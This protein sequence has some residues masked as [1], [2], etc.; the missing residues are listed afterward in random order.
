MCVSFSVISGGQWCSSFVYYTITRPS[1]HAAPVGSVSVFMYFANLY[2]EEKEEIMLCL[3][4]SICENGM[5][6]VHIARRRAS[7]VYDTAYLSVPRSAVRHTQVLCE[8][9]GTQRDAIFTV[10]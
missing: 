9:E 4:V 7:A 6:T 8:N 10:G 2:G 1:H 5:N 3:P